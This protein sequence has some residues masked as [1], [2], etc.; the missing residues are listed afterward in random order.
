[1]N[2]PPIKSLQGRSSSQSVRGVNTLTADLP[3]KQF[4]KQLSEGIFQGMCILH[5]LLVLLV[6]QAYHP[7]YAAF[8]HPLKLNA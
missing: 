1:V 8:Y 5:L 4:E 6:E 7:A 2:N 3:N